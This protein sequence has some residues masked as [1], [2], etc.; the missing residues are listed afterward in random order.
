MEAWQLLFDAFPDMTRVRHVACAASPLGRRRESE[1]CPETQEIPVERYEAVVAAKQQQ[2]VQ[3][4]VAEPR[5]RRHGAARP[6]ERPPD[7]LRQAGLPTEALDARQQRVQ[8]LVR[9]RARQ[10]TAAVS[11]ARGARN[12]E[13]GV[14]AGIRWSAANAASRREGGVWVESA[15]QT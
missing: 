2:P 15:S 5:E 12:I 11:T 3:A 4:A 7:Q 6:T 9:V 8:P 14:S 13:S 10:G 1:P